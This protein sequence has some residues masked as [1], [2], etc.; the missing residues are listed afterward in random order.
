MWNASLSSLS[1]SFY[2]SVAP[3]PSNNIIIRARTSDLTVTLLPLWLQLS[4]CHECMYEW[5]W[6]HTCAAFYA[7]HHMFFLCIHIHTKTHTYRRRSS[8]CCSIIDRQAFRRRQTY[9][10]AKQKRCKKQ[11]SQ[12]FIN[13]IPVEYII[14]YQIYIYVYID[15][16]LYNK[17]FRDGTWRRKRERDS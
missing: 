8:S 17:Q 13:A 9:D 15:T 16:S 14:D 2:F 3:K 7:M 1:L 5:R 4:C 11:A 6:M 10:S 12:I